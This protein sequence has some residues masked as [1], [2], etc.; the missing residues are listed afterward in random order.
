[1]KT[2]IYIYILILILL[3]IIKKLSSGNIH[4]PYKNFLLHLGFW[5]LLKLIKFFHSNYVVRI[6]CLLDMVSVYTSFHPLKVGQVLLIRF[7]IF[8]S[9]QFSAYRLVYCW[10]NLRSILSLV[11]EHQFIKSA[12]KGLA[13]YGDRNYPTKVL[14]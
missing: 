13:N 6:F 2:Y 10:K 1:M 7:W 3:M 12:G 4:Y 11:Y 5:K 8:M 9:K 14:K